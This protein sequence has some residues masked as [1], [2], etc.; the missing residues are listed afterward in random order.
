[1]G[2]N[3][4]YPLVNIQ[5]TNSK[6]PPCLMGKSTILT[7]PFSTAMLNYRRVYVHLIHWL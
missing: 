2:F 3:V 7:G 1:M 5:K 4:I 6:D